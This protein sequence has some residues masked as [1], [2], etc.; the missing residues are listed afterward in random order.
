MNRRQ[1]IPL[2]LAVAAP[3]YAA[4]APPVE[5]WKSP[6][7]SCCGKWVEHM[8]SA[9]FQ[10]RVHASNDLMASRAATGMPAR[11]GACHSAKVGGYAVEGHVPAADVQRLLAE[12][13]RA[14]GIAVPSMPPGSPGMEGSGQ[15]AYDTLV[16]GKDGSATVFARH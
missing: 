13:P 11:Y 2:L 16:V 14:A 1:L 4:D 12:R 8:R 3:S 7:C 10:V 6:Y 15:A 9:G 5:V